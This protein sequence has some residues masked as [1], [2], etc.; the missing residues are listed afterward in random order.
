MATRNSIN[1]GVTAHG[2]QVANSTANG[3]T[4]NTLSNGQV[5]IGSTGAAPVAATITGGSGISVTSG[6][7]SISIAATGG[8]GGGFTWNEINGSV[9]PS[10]TAVVGNGYIL[11]NAPTLTL[12]ANFAV[13]ESVYVV[14]EMNG[15]MTIAAA[16]GDIIWAADR[17]G[18]ANSVITGIFGTGGWTG[19]W[20]IGVVTNSEWAVIA[21]NP[22][23]P[24]LSYDLNP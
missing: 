18:F 14:F 6:A 22:I 4:S 11:K 9:T 12:P 24:N 10:V 5:L 19:V 1:T 20:L 13:G 16:T 15:G 21:S 2:V 17:G 23:Y 8:T 7:G 3:F